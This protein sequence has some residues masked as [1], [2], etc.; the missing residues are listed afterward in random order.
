[1]TCTVTTPSSMCKPR[2]GGSQP[3]TTALRKTPEICGLL[4]S[5][6]DL[7]RKIFSD[8]GITGRC[9]VARLHLDCGS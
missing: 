2:E 3:F 8:P 9:D 1:M 6:E 7:G 4:S 5:S